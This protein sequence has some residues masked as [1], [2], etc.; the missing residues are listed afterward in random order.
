MR[1]LPRLIVLLMIAAIFLSACSMPVVKRQVVPEQPEAETGPV[2]IKVAVNNAPISSTG[3]DAVIAAFQTKFPQYRVEKVQIPSP[4]GMGD[5]K[6]I[7]DAEDTLHQMMKKGDVDLLQAEHGFGIFSAIQK[8]LLTDLMPLVQQSRLDTAPFEPMLSESRQGSALYTMPYAVNPEVFVYNKDLVSKASVTIPQDSWTWDQFRE[9]AASLTKGTG[10]DRVWGFDAMTP[11][12]LGLIWFQ[13]A[14]RFLSQPTQEAASGYLRFLSDMVSVDRSLPQ[15]PKDGAYDIQ[16]H[17]GAA[18]LGLI[19]LDGLKIMS[20]P[21]GVAPYPV[22][23]G[24]KPV[25]KVDPFSFAIPQGSTHQEAAW[26]LL[27]YFLSPDGAQ[28]LATAGFI[29]LA[30]G[31]DARET[32]ISNAATIYGTDL[33]FLKDTQWVSLTAPAITGATPKEALAITTDDVLTGRR[34]WEESLK[35][36][37][38]LTR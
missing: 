7:Q 20:L 24:A 34:T 15:R 22:L 38:V 29:P 4:T 23:P 3:I 31:S 12:D 28:T 32:W 10:T 8:G 2:T 14:T 25:A 17:Q 30:G 27:Q 36:Y 21:I 37:P 11:E 13:Q 33:H 16:F 19:G 1:R 35:L 18:G 9:T 5:P 6:A 26:A